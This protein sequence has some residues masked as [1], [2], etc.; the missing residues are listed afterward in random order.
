M[1]RKKKR[2]RQTTWPH[3]KRTCFFASEPPKVW[4]TQ[5]T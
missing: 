4:H 3:F 1:I 5:S 2:R